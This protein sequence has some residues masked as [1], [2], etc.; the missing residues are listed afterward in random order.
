MTEDTISFEITSPLQ[1][2]NYLKL[3]R[4]NPLNQEQLLDAAMDYLEGHFTPLALTTADKAK[5]KALIYA[6]ATEGEQQ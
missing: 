5:V 2:V 1:A 3:A 6:L 4:Q